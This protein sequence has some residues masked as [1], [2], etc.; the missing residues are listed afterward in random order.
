MFGSIELVKPLRLAS[1]T[2][3]V[4]IRRVD[5]SAHW[6]VLLIS[7]LILMGALHAPLT[8][9]VGLTSYLGVLLLHEC[10]H[11]IAAQ[12]LHCD[13]LAVELYP[14]FAITRF[15]TP[16]TRFDHCLIAWGGVL[17]Q[18]T[19]AIPLVIWV[20]VFGYTR[21][22]AVNA[23]L[24]IWGFFSLGVALFNLL[25][26]GPL[27]GAIAWGLIPALFKRPKKPPVRP[28]NDRGSWR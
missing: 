1:L 23:A 11:V 12:R 13:V 24:A 4:R 16:R 10:G 17:A 28:R 15:E 27:D 3:F 26:V 5:V 19:V 9:L 25:P 7:A 14:V 21:F 6:S 8:S 20:A 22:N 18:F 2:R